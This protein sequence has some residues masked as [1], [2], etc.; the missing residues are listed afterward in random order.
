MKHR[1]LSLLS[2]RRLAALALPA[3]VLA[4]LMAVSGHP[5]QA[6]SYQVRPGDTLR[7][8]VLEDPSLNR[9]VL[10]APDGQISV[11]TAGSLR[12]SGQS[13]EALQRTL[14]DRLAGNFASTPNVFVSLERISEPRIGVA[15]AAAMISVYVM[16]EANSAGRL[17]MAPGTNVLQGFALMGGFTNFAATKRIQLRRVDPRTGQEKIYLLNYKAIEAGGRGGLTTLLD[18]DTIVVPQRRLFE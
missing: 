9:S 16:G 18:G 15:E 13:V 2:L 3:F 7:I 11:P 12:A 6:Q 4:A 5:A 17:E 1:L 14:T 8:E 10:V